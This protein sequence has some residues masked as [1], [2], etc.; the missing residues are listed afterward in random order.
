M[1]LVDP[2]DA[3]WL[4]A[5]KSYGKVRSWFRRLLKT[6][7]PVNHQGGELAERQVVMRCQFGSNDRPPPS[8][9]ADRNLI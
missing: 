5:S 2:D 4:Q 7:Y 3:R 6:V 9:E 8:A 1:Q